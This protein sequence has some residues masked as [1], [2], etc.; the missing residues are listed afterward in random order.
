MRRKNP[1]DKAPTATKEKEESG[2]SCLHRGAVFALW[3]LIPICLLYI[4][5][6]L[7]FESRLDSARRAEMI[8]MDTEVITLPPEWQKAAQV[9]SAEDIE[10]EETVNHELYRIGNKYPEVIADSHSTDTL[11][12]KLQKQLPLEA[13]EQKMLDE[14]MAEFLPV[15]R[16]TSQTASLESH[17]LSMGFYIENW[18]YV[19]ISYIAKCGSVAALELARQGDYRGAIDVAMVLVK[20]VRHHAQGQFISHIISVAC[21]GSAI[22]VIN[23]VISQNDDPGVLHYAL[24]SLDN[25]RDQAYPK[26]MEYWRFSD[27]V[28][29]I[30]NAKAAGYPSADLSP[31]PAAGYV[32]QWFDLNSVSYWRW[33]VDNLPPGDARVTL[34]KRRIRT[35]E[36][37]LSGSSSLR[38]SLDKVA[39]TPTR[40]RVL[41]SLIGYSPAAFLAGY[42]GSIDTSV[43]ITR[44]QVVTAQYELTRLRIAQRLAE[45]ETSATA[46]IGPRLVQPYLGGTV[47]DDPFSSATASGAHAPMRFSATHNRFYSVGP[48]GDDDGMSVL[49]DNDGLS[50]GDVYMVP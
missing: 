1:E 45:L 29:E 13:H 42:F 24:S 39:A 43:P 49:Y 38:N 6:R 12:K 9:P 19:S 21:T 33:L 4:G 17:T 26:N 14:F 10:A 37:R 36:A 22:D 35:E 11:K 34:A 2:K 20:Y 32:D 18:Y 15:V 46:P 8:R 40:R 44:A 50:N 16:M 28:A 3:F 48:D 5:A 30:A 41:Q 25:M 7:W 23:T 27:Y 31:Q 47:P